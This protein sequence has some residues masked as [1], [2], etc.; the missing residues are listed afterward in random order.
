M[1][2]VRIRIFSCGYFTAF[3]LYTEVYSVY[4]H[5][6]SECWK[7]RSRKTP[8]C[9]KSVQIRSFF[10]VHNFSYSVRIRENTEQ[11][12]LRIWTLFTQCLIQTLFVLWKT[13]TAYK[14]S[15]KEVCKFYHLWV[16]G[17]TIFKIT[18]FLSM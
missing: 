4:I 13:F 2:G 6:Q 12:K 18:L 7:I 11:K 16:M 1:T 3:G 14:N 8:H 15:E 5:N 10:L 9:V 17:V